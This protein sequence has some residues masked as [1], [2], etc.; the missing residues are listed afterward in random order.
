MENTQKQDYYEVGKIKSIEE[1][2]NI[3]ISNSSL[4]LINPE[5]G[6][7]PKKFLDFFLGQAEDEEKRHFEFG[8]IVHKLLEGMEGFVIAKNPRP[9]EKAG[10]IADRI[11]SGILEEVKTVTEASIEGCLDVIDNWILDYARREGY[12]G[13]TYKDET[14]LSK[15]KPEVEPYVR[16]KLENPER[17]FL[18]E[19]EYRNYEKMRVTIQ[20]DPAAVKILGEVDE[21]NPDVTIY[22]EL[23]IFFEVNG[24]RF[25][26]KI[27]RVRVN[28]KEKT[29]DIVDFKTTSKD[30][31]TYWES[32]EK[33]HTYRQMFLYLVALEKHFNLDETWSSRMGI[34]VMQKGT[35]F[36]ELLGI[37][38]SYEKFASSEVESLLERITYH[39]KKKIWD[40]SFESLEGYNLL[41]PSRRLMMEHKVV[42]PEII[43][44]HHDTSGME[45]TPEGGNDQ[46]IFSEP[47]EIPLSGET[48]E[49]SSTE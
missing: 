23:E 25:K 33:H 31:S 3:V 11:V 46:E 10:I 49:K 47:R 22:K 9:A 37:N 35:E 8:K 32:F 38:G 12:G 41:S 27:D 30:I 48:E 36:C 21:F 7:H 42:M 5:E 14:I 17:D 13:K 4:S 28:T 29:I 19:Q 24:F 1:I 16:E 15:L 20:K 2:D 26:A 18:T 34:L 45:G 6:G 39:K 40:V 43:Y 44:K